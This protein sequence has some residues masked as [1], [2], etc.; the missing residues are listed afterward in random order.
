QRA[1]ADRKVGFQP[2]DDGM[3]QLPVLVGAVEGQLIYTRLT[4]AAT[5]LPAHDP[6]SM[7]Q[8]RADLLVDAVLSGLPIDA[9]PDMQGRKPSIQVVVSADTLLTLDDQPAHLTGYGPITAETARRLAADKSGT[10]RRLLTDPDTGQL[11]DISQDRYRPSQRLRDFINAR[12]NVCCFPTCHQPGYRCHYEHITPYLQGGETCRC[13]AALARRRHNNCKINSDWDYTRNPDGTFT[14]TTDT[15]HPYTSHPPERWTHPS[16]E[17]RPEPPR[18]ATLEEIHTN[19]D[20]AYATLQ[21][22]WQH[23]LNQATETGDHTRITNAEQ[24]ITAAQVQRQRQLAHRADPT[25]SPF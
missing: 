21:K 12:D 4:A 23:E 15:G 18:Q 10:W 3:V 16:H 25:K 8:K 11:L 6:R 20:T 13:N 7:D 19:E 22:R 2:G 14:W 24:A 9:L 17:P 1:L 5:L